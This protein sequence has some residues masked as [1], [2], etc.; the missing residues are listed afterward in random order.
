MSISPFRFNLLF[1]L[2]IGFVLPVSNSF[3]QTDATEEMQKE[4][5]VTRAPREADGPLAWKFKEGLSIKIAMDQT[6]NIEMEMGWE[7]F[8]TPQIFL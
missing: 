6:N 3:A 4:E 7:P 8:Y 1:L 2:L 5:L